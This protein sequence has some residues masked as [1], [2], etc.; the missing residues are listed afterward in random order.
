MMNK[1]WN[2]EQVENENEEGR[3]EERGEKEKKSSI[4][5]KIKRFRK[6]KGEISRKI[7]F[8]ESFFYERKME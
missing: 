8:A 1:R 4:V 6:K 7:E 2:N 3:E 5:K